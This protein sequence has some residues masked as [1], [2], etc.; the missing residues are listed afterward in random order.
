MSQYIIKFAWY[1]TKL[2]NKK[3]IF[4]RK[5]YTFYTGYGAKIDVNG[6]S[7]YP[8]TEKL[9]EEDAIIYLLKYN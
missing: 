1:P 7:F 6:A 9:S 5:Y 3:W 2:S 8:T 4:F